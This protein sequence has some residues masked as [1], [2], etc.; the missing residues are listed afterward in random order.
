MLIQKIERLEKLVASTLDM[1]DNLQAEKTSLE[2]RVRELEKEK[3]T[4][5]KEGGEIKNSLEK[6]NQ[7]KIFY[8]KL[9]KDR[10][11]IRLKVNNA[12]QRIEKMN[13]F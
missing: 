6:F 8:R 11:A 9:E 2:R 5:L 10:T 7:L 1:L 13:F 3:N 4:A 12:L